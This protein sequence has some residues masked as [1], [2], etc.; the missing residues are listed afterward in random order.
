MTV[1]WLVRLRTRY[2][3]PWARGRKRLSVGPSSTQARRTHSMPRSARPPLAPALAIALAST[4]PTGSLAD[5]GAKAS[6]ACAWSA[7]NPRIRS[8]TRRAFRGV[9]RTYRAFAR[10]SIIV[11]LLS[12]TAPVV[13]DV[14]AESPRGRELAKL[15]AHHRL[16]DEHRDVLATVV[17]GDRVPEHGRD[18]HRTPGPRP[19][20]R[21]GS[22]VVLHVHLLHQVVVHEG[23][24]LKA[25]RHRVL[26]LPLVPA[27]A[28][29][30]QPVTRLVR[31]AGPALRLAPRAD[32]V[33]SAR[34]LAL[35]AAKRVVDRVHGHTADGR[36]LALPPVPAGL[37]Q[38]DVALLG[39]AH[40]A[41][42]GP[43]GRVDPPDLTGRHPQLG[44]AAL[45]GE[46]LH[47][48]TRGPG[49]LGAA[50]RTQLDG[51]HHRAG[52]DEAQRQRVTGL[53][54]RPG[55]ALHPVALGQAGRADDVAL[56]AVRVVQQGDPRGA[57]RVVLDVRDLGR[58][59]VLVR[60]PEVDQPV[61]P[62][63]AAA[64]MPGGDA[65]VHVPAALRVQRAHQRLLRLTPGDL[66]EVRAA[67]A[68]PA[69]RGRLV[70]TDSHVWSSPLGAE[71]VDPVALGEGDDRALGVRPLAPAVP[72]ATPL[73]RPVHGV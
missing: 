53:D 36:A 67:R 49:D 22:P 45:L 4:L 58:H 14:T 39:V 31:P 24:L 9:T 55:T 52:R 69:R 28:T 11:V 71:N 44:E 10:A 48:G 1:M 73:A 57:V 17:D 50:A 62:L 15:V 42:G 23:A 34:A 64:L 18:D 68:A 32:R 37:A 63:V 43:A 12:A 40:R 8:T 60:P 33:T 3:R 70:L 27:A 38:L 19:D 25:T 16:G 51:V 20:D 26:L 46:Q 47:P 72:G 5:C 2:P 21:F 30:D 61:G 35:A 6:T 13:L 59:A 56:L 7:G 66:G 41:D 65:A 54:V 29:A